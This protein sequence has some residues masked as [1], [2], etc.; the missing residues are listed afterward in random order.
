MRLSP[1]LTLIAIATVL[2]SATAKTLDDSAIVAG[3]ERT[4]IANGWGYATQDV[5]PR[6]T[7]SERAKRGSQNDRTIIV[8]GLEASG[9]RYVSRGIAMAADPHAAFWDAWTSWRCPGTVSTA[10]ARE[11][12]GR[13]F[14]SKERR[15][16]IRGFLPTHS[17]LTLSASLHHF[18]FSQHLRRKH[19]QRR[20][21][22]VRQCS[23]HF[24][25]LKSEVRSANCPA[26]LCQGSFQR[27]VPKEPP[28]PGFEV[29]SKLPVCAKAVNKELYQATI[30]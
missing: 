15:E 6:L 29:R 3:S 24:P 9:T 26:A 1:H 2:G 5:A 22:K 12:Y 23:T 11:A 4:K 8:F 28:L 16:I 25:S 21:R 17:S 19:R 14:E 30:P 20:E 27:Q 18:V 13:G 10:R 7:S